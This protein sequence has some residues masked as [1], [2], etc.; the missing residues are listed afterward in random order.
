MDLERYEKCLCVEQV[1]GF[2]KE[3]IEFPVDSI[4]LFKDG[5]VRCSEPFKDLV[6]TLEAVSVG[7]LEVWSMNNQHRRPHFCF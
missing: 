2:T 5:W 3:I 1:G 6:L 4:V 7:V